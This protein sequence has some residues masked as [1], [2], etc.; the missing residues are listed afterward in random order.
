[1]IIAFLGSCSSSPED[2]T[3]IIVTM[4]TMV[5]MVSMV[6]IVSSGVRSGQSVVK[7]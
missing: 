6:S 7:W 2:W 1:M 4:V 3:I 5:S